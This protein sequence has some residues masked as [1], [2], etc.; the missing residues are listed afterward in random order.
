M[1]SRTAFFV[2]GVPATQG[3]KRLVRVR[4][5]NRSIMLE[6]SERT[7]PWRELVGMVARMNA[8]PM[9][10]GDVE[11][12]IVCR[13]PRPPSHLRADGT[14]RPSAPARPSY[15]DADKLARAICDALT[16]IAYRDDRQV[17]KL[18]VE[19][20]WARSGDC[21]GAHIELID[22]TA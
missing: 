15:G 17:A 9:L 2:A 1:R 22:L 3:S 6:A 13:W 18:S 5:S 11:M 4:N 7:K 19:R 12:H 14:P 16:G 10:A 8:V 20:V 21:A